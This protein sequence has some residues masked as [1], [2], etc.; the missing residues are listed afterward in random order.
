MKRGCLSSLPE[1]V[2]VD[3]QKQNDTCKSCVGNGC[4]SKD[5]FQKCYV[6]NSNDTVKCIRSP[7]SFPPT[8]CRSYIDECF[9]HVWDDVVTRGCLTDPPTTSLNITS[10][11]QNKDKCEK[12]SGNKTCNNKIIGGEFCLTCDSNL[13]P[14]CRTNVSI[15]M[16]TQCPLSVHPLGC[17]RFEDEN[18]WEVKRGCLANISHY[19]IEMCRRESPLC[20]TCIGDDCNA[21][22]GFQKCINCFSKTDL[23]CIRYSQGTTEKLCKR[24]HDECFTHVADDIVTRGCLSEYQNNPDIDIEEDCSN[25]DICEKCSD[26]N[27]CNEKIVDGEF[28]ITCDSD[29]D[30][31]CRTN[32][33][34][35]MRTQCPLAVRPVGCYRYED[36][37]G[38]VVK[39][40]CLSNVTH[41]EIEMCRTQSP[42]CKTCIGNDCNA[43]RTFQKCHVCNSSDSVNCIRAPWTFKTQ[44]CRNY[45]D[46]CFVHVSNDVVI[47]GC[48]AEQSNDTSIKQD[49]EN[50]DICEKCSKEENCNNQVVDGEF[51]LSC[52]SHT[53]PNCRTNVSFAMRTQCPLTVHPLGCYRFEDENGS[54]I[55]RGCL[56]NVT[57]YEIEMCRTQSALCKTCLGD[58]CNAKISFQTCRECS[59]KNNTNCIRYPASAHVK[60]C[61]NYVDECFTH[62]AGDV[63]TRGCLQ[64]YRNHNETDFLQDCQNPDICEACDKDGCN[65]KVIDGEFCLTCDSD[66]DPNCRTNVSITMRTQC[67]LAVKPL[68]CYHFEDEGGKIVKR[69]CLS[70]VTSN[71][72]EMCR[73]ESSLCKTCLG[74]D[75]NTKP[76]FSECYTCGPDPLCGLVPLDT[77]QCGNYSDQCFVH[78]E[79]NKVTRGCLQETNTSIKAQC[80]G[81][82]TKCEICTTKNCNGYSVEHETCI[83]CDSNSD[84]D[85]IAN[86]PI[87]ALG[88]TCNNP[89]PFEHFG[90]Y[91]MKNSSYVKR[92]CINELD[93]I[94]QQGC[95]SNSESC[96]TCHG[97]DCNR[98]LEFQQCYKCDPH[99]NNQCA[100]PQLNQSLTEV[101]QNYSDSC[102]ITI[103]T[104]GHTH[105]GCTSTLTFDSKKDYHICS[106]NKCNGIIFPPFRL[107]CH[108]CNGEK[109]CNNI[110]GTLSPKPCTLY[111][112]NDL[113]YTYI[114]AGK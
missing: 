112:T 99:S 3:C 62:V 59:S 9:V 32:L 68:G 61:R 58:D 89:S 54:L 87:S 101:C 49:C 12:C 113:C 97:R 21:K 65:E 50:N 74:D 60:H 34:I 72:I 11:C 27:D 51:C 96:K 77:K 88:K 56:S 52:D 37:N 16:R 47:R 13:D 91:L 66:S 14:N 25:P 46:E 110:Q 41:Y 6:C 64:D 29:K 84:P 98:K 39:R 20:K 23:S 83:T 43:K 78:I 42:L 57:H 2:L 45:L 31:Q 108:Q 100:Q 5:G 36:E 81:N 4:N 55:K 44:T 73:T 35:A 105:R 40:G 90:C 85:C 114:K 104:D 69:G 76:T 17:Y 19:E 26:K 33:S 107:M 102:A 94:T 28:C 22:L 18:G 30:P 63:I 95:L 53:D 106:G 1:D 111:T 67:P 38:D 75:C 92:G 15:A 7:G 103:E 48:L 24:Y 70:N 79:E 93:N 71:E 86:I 82:N 10:E 109:E 80:Q 8:I